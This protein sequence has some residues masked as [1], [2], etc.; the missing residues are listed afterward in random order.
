MQKVTVFVIVVALLPL[1]LGACEKDEQKANK[2][3]A[4]SEPPAKAAQSDPDPKKP[5]RDEATG[6]TPTSLGDLPE[7][8][9]AVQNEMQKLDEA[10]KVILTLI[11][12]D[13]LQ[14]IP[15]Q[16]KK[17][18][19]A[20][21]LTMKAVEQGKYKPPKNADNMDEFKKLDDEF[22]KDL[23]DLLEAS[24]NDDLQAATDAYSELVQGCTNCHTKFRFEGRSFTE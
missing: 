17:V 16:L 22:H 14:G 10:M 3:V 20:R 24:K 21:Q 23:Q 1:L 19:P 11:A 7:G 6:G 13:E 12:N 4:E 9:N 2:E 15:P 18:H 5:V 8:T